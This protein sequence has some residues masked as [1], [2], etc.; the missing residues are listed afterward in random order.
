[1]C[2]LSIPATNA[3]GSVVKPF[4]FEPLPLGSIKPQGWLRDQVQ[5]MADGLA[6][7]EYDFYH[8]IRYSPWLGGNSE[9][10]PLNEG[11]PYWF[12][13]LVPL[14]YALDDTRLKVQ[15]DFV[16]NDI[17]LHQQEDGWL[18]PET[19]LYTRYLWGRFPLFLGMIQLAEAEPSHAD[20]IIIALYKFIKLMH[21]MLTNNEGLGFWGK[22]RYQAMLIVLQWLY[23]KYPEGNE[24]LLLESMHFL[25]AR[26]RDWGMYY[27]EK[28]FP[29]DDLD[30]IR[31]PIWGNTSM[32]AF[33]H[34][35]NA[36]QG[37]LMDRSME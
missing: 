18:G 6:G 31:P 2:T 25:R 7:H 26:G 10:S 3:N 4:T 22:V 14:A 27:D 30:L 24:E 1:M 13:G 16:L 8:T 15:V 11:I 29:F 21:V 36:V 19:T 35:V 34:G 12:N 17:L 37:T 9:Y 23:E 28:R 20:R 5:L 33:V 32:F